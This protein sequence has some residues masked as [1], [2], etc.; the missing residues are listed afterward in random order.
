MKE[1]VYSSLA[2]IGSLHFNLQMH[3]SVP[4]PY[5]I[6]FLTWALFSFYDA[7][8]S[9]SRW[10]LLQFYF[11]IGCGL[12]TKGP[13]S[14]AL[15]GISAVAFLL[16]N[17]DFKW[18][19]IWR[20]QPFGGVLLSLMVET[21]WYY[22]VHLATDGLWTY[23]FFFKHNFSRFGDAMEGHEGI[24]LLTFGYVFILGFLGVLPFVFQAVKKTIKNPA[25]EAQLWLIVGISVIV[26][27]FAFS[28]TKLP[29][30]TTP[31]YPL[32]A[33]I[34]GIYLSQVKDQWLSISWNRVGLIAYAVL[35][36]FPVGIYFGV[37]ADPLLEDKAF[38]ALFFIIL[39]IV[40]I[41]LLIG[42][43][44]RKVDFAIHS[45]LT[46][47]IAMIIL[48]FHFAYPPIDARNP[49]ARTRDLINPDAKLIA[50]QRLN[51]A[52]VFE[53]ERVIPRYQE[54]SEVK[55]AM[56]NNDFGYVISRTNWKDELLSIPG[57]KVEAEVKDIFE[58]PTTLILSWGRD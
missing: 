52:F 11:A 17:K 25:K 58:N 31:S 40:G 50:Y 42:I 49:M 51:A 2:L 10:S 23:E 48:F 26:I 19:T 20:M 18:K 7:Y 22:Q 16:V 27:F 8:K 43:K 35:L 55:Q 32:I 38:V 21:P 37:K 6:F 1:A 13:I 24:F 56:S 3:M 9:N 39:T 36:L 41:Q 44:K 4:D 53:Y 46:G 30:Y 29:N 12:L 57:L 15:S 28:S 5:L 33:I 54:L 45:L 14:L 34:T 47:W